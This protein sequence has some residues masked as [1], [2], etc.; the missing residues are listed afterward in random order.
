MLYIQ[1]F[2]LEYKSKQVPMVASTEVPYTVKFKELK[3][4]GKNILLSWTTREH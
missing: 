1:G 4:G 2:T 3:R